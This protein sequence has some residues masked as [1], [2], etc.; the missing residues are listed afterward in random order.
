MSEL[1]K[2]LLVKLSEESAEVVQAA[3]KAL[4]FGLDS[5]PDTPGNWAPN[6]EYVMREFADV[7]AAVEMLQE[8]GALPSDDEVQLK[9]LKRA[10]KI[11][12][13]KYVDFS[14]KKIRSI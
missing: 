1:T 2:L 11:K 12:F 5:V 3:C 9:N 4:R 13:Q 10:A 6:R 14:L 8:A 7:L